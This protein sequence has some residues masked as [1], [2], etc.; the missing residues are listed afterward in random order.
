[1]KNLSTVLFFF[2]LLTFLS[3][4]VGFAQPQWIVFD[5]LNSPLKNNVVLSLEHDKYDNIWI[6][7]HYGLLKFDGFFWQ[8]Y[9][10]SN[11]GLM[12]N[13]LRKIVIDKHSNLWFSA[14]HSN[15]PYFIK[16]DGINW[17]Q[18]DTNQTCIEEMYHSYD[19]AVEEN[20]AKWVY[21]KSAHPYSRIIRIDED[22][23]NTF[24]PGTL[25]LGLSRDFTVAPD[26]SFWFCT[27]YGTN[28]SGI[29]KYLNS[30]WQIHYV[31]IS[32]F[33]IDTT[34]Y[35]VWYGTPWGLEKIRFDDLFYLGNYNY[36]SGFSGD[37][38]KYFYLDKNY[39]PW[40]ASS[41]EGLFK[42][43][44]ILEEYK[45]YSKSNSEL[46]SDTVRAIAIDSSNN[47]WIGTSKGL[48]VLI[49]LILTQQFLTIMVPCQ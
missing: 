33:V 37:H 29:A 40:Y 9:D 45:Q 41:I 1:M 15:Y 42:F 8:L 34:N 10:T 17:V 16:F 26:N 38:P 12:Y 19:F 39:N 13:E 49:P 28:Y 5:S 4:S 31:L 27:E 14:S 3:S 18:T 24:K 7:T 2:I 22:S 46:P 36:P 20:G 30:N 48:A 32:Q 25:N 43:D 11:S 47:I 6:G 44:R 35:I 21:G 23:C